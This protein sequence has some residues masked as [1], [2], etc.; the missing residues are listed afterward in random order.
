MRSNNIRVSRHQNGSTYSTGNPTIP[1]SI[2]IIQFQ[3]LHQIGNQG[4]CS[5]LLCNSKASKDKDTFF[6]FSV[7]SL[8]YLVSRDDAA[9]DRQGPL[10]L[11]PEAAIFFISSPLSSLFFANPTRTMPES[12]ALENLSRTL[13]K[14][15]NKQRQTSHMLNRANA[16]QV[17]L[18]PELLECSAC[19]GFSCG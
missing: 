18:K 15:E 5:G 9:S 4:T 12:E 7:I 16:S 17:H 11:P 3:G 1:S 10:A 19:N 2:R 14:Y 13:A 8:V 6:H